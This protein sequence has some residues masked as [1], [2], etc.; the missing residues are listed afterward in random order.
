MVEQGDF[1]Q[2]LAKSASLDVIIVCLADAPDPAVRRAVRRNVEVQSLKIPSVKPDV[3]CSVS[4]GLPE[5]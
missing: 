3:P 4:E 1:H 5:G 2:E